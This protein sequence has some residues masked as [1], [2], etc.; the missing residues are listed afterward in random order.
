MADRKLAPIGFDS[1]ADARVIN[2][3]F[4]TAENLIDANTASI[5]NVD[6]KVDTEETRAKGVENTIS[7]NLQTE[8]T[9]ATTAEG[10]L[11]TDIATHTTQIANIQTTI[12]NLSQSISNLQENLADFIGSFNTKADLLAYSG[13]LTNNDWAVVLDDETHSNQCWQYIYKASTTTWQAEF[14]INEKPLTQT[15]WDAVNSG[16][17]AALVTQIGTN[18][19]NIAG[20]Q[21]QLTVSDGIDQRYFE[22]S[23]IIK[24][25]Y[26]D[27]SSPTPSTTNPYNASQVHTLLSN[28]QDTLVSGTNIKT[29][30][31]DSI[32]GNGNIVIPQIVQVTQEPVSPDP[33]TLYVLTEEPPYEGLTFTGAQN[34]SSVGYQIVGTL[35]SGRINIQIS[36]DNGHTWESWDGTSVVL[37]TGDKV[38]V[39]NTTNYLSGNITQYVNFVMTGRVE[40]SGNCDSLINFYSYV[41]LLAYS[42]LFKDC[43]SLITAPDLPS[44]TVE[45][46][47]YIEMFNGCSNLEKAPY[48]AATNLSSGVAQMFKNCSSLNYIK[49]A[50]TGNF[51]ASFYEWVY[52]VPATGDFYY[53]GSD[54]TRGVNAIPTGWTVHTF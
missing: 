8:V 52:G 30:N 9:R 36:N 35:P 18:T 50:Y 37:N 45:N 15:Q 34:N 40:A 20:K 42:A 38:C 13:S 41:P 21:D 39:R 5:N 17:T 3:N 11:S 49:I 25:A 22:R 24:I 6:G 2:S 51:S 16:I 43:T 44:T 10:N 33:N 54:T 26:A 47:G 4:E 46:G 23:N 28:K 14:M 27:P 7:G 32:L 19:T 53:N 48:I 31:D 12:G 1:A 29:I